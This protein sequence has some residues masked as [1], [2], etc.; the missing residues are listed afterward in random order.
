MINDITVVDNALKHPDILLEKIPQIDFW[1][2][3]YHPDNVAAGWEGLRS[4]EIAT[5]DKDFFSSVVNEC[6]DK[7]F[8]VCYNDNDRR[9]QT[10]GT[11][12]SYLHYL[13]KNNQPKSSWLH[14]DQAVALAG[15]LYLS[16]SPSENTGT[17]IW[18]N[19]GEKVIVPNCFNRF[20]LYRADYDHRPLQGFGEDKSNARLTLN[21]FIKEYS[22]HIC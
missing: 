8:T 21:I 9:I 6:F 1:E 13:T 2:N 18:R 14:K 16:K 11:F 20:V 7:L 5:I 3:Q 19:T 15:V 12:M 10:Q 22:I 17:E 4:K